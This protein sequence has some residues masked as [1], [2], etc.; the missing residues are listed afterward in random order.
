MM[1]IIGSIGL[2]YIIVAL[3][4]ILILGFTNAKT[5]HAGESSV[6]LFS[7]GVGVFWLPLL[8]FFVILIL[9]FAVFKLGHKLGQ[10]EVVEQEATHE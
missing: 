4:V 8:L 2:A 1:L 9:G 7:V 10:K 3:L 5:G 6:A